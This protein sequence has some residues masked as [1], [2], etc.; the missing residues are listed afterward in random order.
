MPASWV[1]LNGPE[2]APTT[3]YRALN[4]GEVVAIALPLTG[5][6]YSGDIK[7][8]MGVLANGEVLGVRVLS[9]AETPGLGDKIEVQK[10]EWILGFAGLSF[11]TLAPD[12]WKVKKDGGTFDQFS[13]AT[14]T[15][16]AVVNAVKRG[17]DFV[18]GH[19]DDLFAIGTV[20]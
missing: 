4:H 11:A 7:L 10:N 17:L 5:Q 3:V 13:G 19:H 14:I 18:V 1:T 2:G 20:P 9:H 12:Q 16:R 8:L 6:G 15:P